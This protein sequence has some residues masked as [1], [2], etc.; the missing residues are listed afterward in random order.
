MTNARV[1]H[2]HAVLMLTLIRLV[3][4]DVTWYTRRS[5]AAKTGRCNSAEAPAASSLS[6]MYVIEHMLGCWSGEVVS[7]CMLL[8]C[9][10]LAMDSPNLI[11]NGNS[12]SLSVSRVD[13][14]DS[15]VRLFR[16]LRGVVG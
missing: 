4:P 3:Y 15:F 11:C 13:N 9:V 16:L 6:A 5:S 14:S 10:V 1:S 2:E 8:Y 12:P 7:V